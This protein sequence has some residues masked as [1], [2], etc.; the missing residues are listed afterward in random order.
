MGVEN[1][2]LSKVQKVLQKDNAAG[3]TCG[4]LFVA[5]DEQEARQVFHCLSQEFGLGKVQ[6]HGPIQGEYA[7]DIM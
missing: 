2:I 4:T 1:R 3:F 5:C 6:V 7:Y